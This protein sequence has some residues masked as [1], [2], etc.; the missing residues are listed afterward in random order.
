MSGSNVLRKAKLP[1]YQ[2]NINKW[3]GITTSAGVVSPL[4]LRAAGLP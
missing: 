4:K 2:A 1:S 3:S